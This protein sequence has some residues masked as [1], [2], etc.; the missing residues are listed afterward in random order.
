MPGRVGI[1]AV[2]LDPPMGGLETYVRE[3]MPELVRLAPEVGFTVFVNPRGRAALAR[4]EWA[5]EVELLA[6]P[7][8]GRRGMRAL[9]ELSILGLVAGAR[10]DLLHSVAL[11]APVWTRAVNVVMIADTT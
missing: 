6:H 10:V 1:N 7:L 9:A 4:E 2:F 3:L 8:I 11:T 5:G